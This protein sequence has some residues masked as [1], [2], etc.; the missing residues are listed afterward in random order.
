MLDV[1]LL[2]IGMLYANMPLEGM[3]DRF[4]LLEHML[5][6]LLLHE[7][8]WVGMP[9]GG[10]VSN[11]HMLIEGMLEVCMLLECMLEVFLLLED[12]MHVC[13]LLDISLLP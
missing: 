4:L 12:I 7:D 2:S 1:D 9:D 10:L 8:L 11:V 5:H 3:L 6:S 13:D